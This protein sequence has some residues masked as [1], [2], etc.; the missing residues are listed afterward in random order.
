[1]FAPEVAAR[2]VPVA[3]FNLEE[4]PVTGRFQYSDSYFTVLRFTSLLTVVFHDAML[5]VFAPSVH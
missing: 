4:T 1:M 2:G 3:E 5:M